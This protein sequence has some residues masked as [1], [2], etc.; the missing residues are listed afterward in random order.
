[1]KY[2]VE[3]MSRYSG[4][5]SINLLGIFCVGMQYH[6][7]PYSDFVLVFGVIL[8]YVS[9]QMLDDNTKFTWRG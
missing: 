3:R 7:Q 9:I 6:C 5:K 4:W 2:R 1:M 8:Y